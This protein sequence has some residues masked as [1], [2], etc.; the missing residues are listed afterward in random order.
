M[1]IVVL[2]DWEAERM[3]TGQLRITAGVACAFLLGVIS[4]TAADPP[5]TAPSAVETLRSQLLESSGD[6][7]VKARDEALHLLPSKFNPLLAL[8]DSADPISQDNLIARILRTRREQPA[9]AIEFDEQLQ[10]SIHHPEGGSITGKPIY[11]AWWPHDRIDVDPLA[12]ETIMKL[13]LP[14][15]GRGLLSSFHNF[16]NRKNPA[17]INTLMYLAKERGLGFAFPLID[18]ALGQPQEQARITPILVGYH[19]QWRERGEH[20][21]SVYYVLGSFG[22]Q[23]QLDALMEIKD[24]EQSRIDPLTLEVW[25]KRT[26]R[27]DHDAAWEESQIASAKIREAIV[28]ARRQSQPLS[29][30]RPLYEQLNHVNDEVDAIAS[31]L[32]PRLNW[33]QLNEQISELS[34]KLH[35][36]DNN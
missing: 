32:E 21:S 24:W 34:A 16:M 20:A 33:E 9:V 36:P 3:K 4:F 30:F 10:R 15:G 22:N 14:T 6:A 35:P 12:F 13:E 8:L 29:V 5:T 17:N 23:L 27:E 26:Y 1:R 25:N 28:E 7:Y 2:E 31:Q 11:H 19:K 18:A